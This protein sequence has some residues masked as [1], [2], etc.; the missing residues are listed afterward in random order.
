MLLNIIMQ[1]IQWIMHDTF[2]SDWNIGFQPFLDEKKMFINMHA[3][4]ADVIYSRDTFVRI[5]A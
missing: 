3:S 2:P 1:I 5:S 4:Y